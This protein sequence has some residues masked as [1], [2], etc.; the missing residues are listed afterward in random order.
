MFDFILRRTPTPESKAATDAQS[1]APAPKQDESAKLLALSQ[2]EELAQDEAGA[3]TFILACGFADARLRAAQHVHSQPMLEQVLQAMRKTDRRVARLMQTR[4]DDI[5]RQESTEKYAQ[6]CIAEAQR[7]AQE[8][9]LMAN[10]VADLDRRWQLAGSASAQLQSAFEQLR[11]Q[12]AQRLA[13]QASL[14]RAVID[15]LERTRELEAELASLA[16][17]VRQETLDRLDAEL[18][19]HRAAPEAVSLPAHLLAQLEQECQR[20]GK[21]RSALARH[22]AAL[23]A[24]QDALAAW[25]AAADESLDRNTL[26]QTWNEMP[27]LDDARL[28][29]PLQHRFEA[30]LQ[31]IAQQ[32]VVQAGAFSAKDFSAVLS[33]LEQALQDG[34]L[35]VAVEQD[36]ILR[37]IDLSARK[38]DET[39]IARLAE[40]RAELKRLQGWAKW[41]GNVSREGLIDAVAKLAGQSLPVNQLAKT[42]SVARQQWKTLDIASGAAPKTLWERF[43]AACNTAYAPVAEHA[44]KQSQERRQNRE[45]AEKLLADLR[46]FA[47][48]AGF[49]GELASG[50]TAPN[51]K[52]VA[53]HCRNARQSWQRLG[54]MDRKERKRLDAEFD[55]VLKRMQQPLRE[56]WQQEIAR[57]ESLIAD[58]E[59]I[60][61]EDRGAADQ[62][63]KMQARWQELARATPLER[64]DEQPLWQ[65][66]RAACDAVFSRRRELE[67]AADSERRR[68]AQEK[69]ILCATLEAALDLSEN[70]SRKLLRETAAAWARVGPV[71]RA[72]ERLLEQRYRRAAAALQARVDAAKSAARDTEFRAVLEKLSLCQAAEAAV[73]ANLALDVG[74]AAHWQMLP[75][76]APK[77]E[78]L[79]RTRFDAAHAAMQSG[80]RN[81]ADGLETARPVLAQ[82]LLRLEILA[83]I[84]S[85]P[86]LSRERLQMQVVVLQSALAGQES[87]ALTGQVERLCGMAA[88]ADEQSSAR[89]RQ[90][91]EKIWAV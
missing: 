44:K 30:L 40:A 8:M 47:D 1:A 88:L 48:R 38:P 33:A 82:E 80:D 11:Q 36:E 61:P 37:S 83:G 34:M 46:Q 90:L 55:G 58:A 78:A 86:E 71:P 12:I 79:M 57:R 67:G 13:A 39:Q 41:G 25:E 84:A 73:A 45:A 63:R 52:D 69:E 2:A 7:M 5:R 21:I 87:D 91:L 23:G 62:V 66:F 56:Q 64:R 35:H 70:E 85:P 89:L 15:V 75:Q 28:L 22:A 51:W 77:W 24:R 60:K 54:H 43:D 65:R 4:L 27:A 17:E 50:A 18:T 81:Y 72:E 16:P 20:V 59:R 29:A 26:K 10:R 32:P 53:N 49:G 3:V 74:W 19:R 9:P 31:K 6:D 42:V 14:Q 68:H 76:L